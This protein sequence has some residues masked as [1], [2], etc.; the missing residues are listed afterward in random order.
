M[1]FNGCQL[2]LRTLSREVGEE[3]LA[4]A[5]GLKT[6]T[7]TLPANRDIVQAGQVGGAVQIVQRGWAF[8]YKLWPDGGRQILDFLLPG[9]VIGLESGLLG[10]IEHSVRPLTDIELCLIDGR[11][12]DDLFRSHARLA[13]AVTKY[14]SLGS[15]RMDTRLS[16][17][18]RRTALE[19]IAHLML[20]L[21][22]R[23]RRGS[24]DDGRCAFPLRRQ[25]IADATGLTGA[26]VNRILNQMR[27]ERIAAI[28]DNELTIHDFTKLSA[29]AGGV[30]E[31]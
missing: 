1:P 23:Q 11:R 15:R 24:G 16:V 28:G 30:A 25:H 7:A 18:G 13:M 3:D 17:I 10:M 5:V 31:G 9:D 4:W 6:G 29:L 27:N 8:R 14:L 21:Y 2:R 22:Q 20:D 19:R 26:H 12:F